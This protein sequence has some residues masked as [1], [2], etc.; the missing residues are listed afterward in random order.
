MVAG[1][2]LHPDRL[3]IADGPRRASPGAESKRFP[4]VTVTNE[5]QPRTGS[6][7]DVTVFWSPV[8]VARDVNRTSLSS[9]IARTW[10]AP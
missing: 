4:Y 10:G 3:R 1:R 5:R 2:Q 8:L 9:V 6:R 7:D